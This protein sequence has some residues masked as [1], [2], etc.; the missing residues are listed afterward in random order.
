MLIKLNERI[1]LSDEVNGARPGVPVAVIGGKLH[2]PTDRVG[3]GG[4]AA[5]LVQ[6]ECVMARLHGAI[7]TDQLMWASRFWK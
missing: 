5:E 2:K 6:A 7:T 3:K 4:H 1:T